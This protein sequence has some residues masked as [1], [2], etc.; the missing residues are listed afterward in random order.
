M[1]LG[2]SGGSMAAQVSFDSSGASGINVSGADSSLIITTDS[3]LPESVNAE[4]QGGAACKVSATA[5]RSG[6]VVEVRIQRQGDS[7]RCTPIVRLNIREGLNLGV[8]LSAMKASLE[9]RYRTVSLMTQ[10]AD[11]DFNAR[12]EII[13]LS[14]KAL[15]AAFRISPLRE[16]R[17]I[18]VKSDV[19][20]FR[21]QGDEGS[22]LAYAIDVGESDFSRGIPESASGTRLEI[23]A[24]ALTGF[25]MLGNP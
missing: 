4:A 25:T 1:L 17:L 11:V 22:S 13:N 10:S 6:D 19:V 23:S 24:D 9:G 21:L 14:S 7:G 15:S 12:A 2:A 18:R 8:G 20:D 16:T 3:S 5:E